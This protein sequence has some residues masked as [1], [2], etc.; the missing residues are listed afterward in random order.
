MQAIQAK[1]SFEVLD[2]GDIPADIPL[3][4][5]VGIPYIVFERGDCD[6]HSLL[7]GGK[8]TGFGW[9]MAT[10]HQPAVGIQEL[11]RLKSRTKEPQ[12]FERRLF[13]RAAGQ[14]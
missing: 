7:E 5:R 8:R 4:G 14:R 12:T 9:H 10:L 1:K 2:H 3:L 11:H 6:A 13:R